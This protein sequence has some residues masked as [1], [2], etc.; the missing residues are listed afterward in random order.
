MFK[1]IT[2]YISLGSSW[3]DIFIANNS[4]FLCVRHS[5]PTVRSNS[6]YCR[7]C[8]R[9]SKAKVNKTTCWTPWAYSTLAFFGDVSNIVKKKK[10][11]KRNRIYPFC[12]VKI[13]Q[14]CSNKK[15]QR[16][17][18]FDCKHHLNKD[19]IYLMGDKHDKQTFSCRLCGCGDLLL[20]GFTSCACWVLTAWPLNVKPQL[21]SKH[22][23]WSMKLFVS[24]CVCS[25]CV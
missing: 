12:G 4:F 3:K 21:G 20:T 11:K 6:T 9:L 10:K 2:K 19:W 23:H 24:V 13:T 14:Y 5:R 18:N 7:K 15:K 1:N 16:I 8:T 22:K 17:I 25:V